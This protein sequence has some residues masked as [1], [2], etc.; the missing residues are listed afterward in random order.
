MSK[1]RNVPSRVRKV[2]RVKHRDL[3]GTGAEATLPGSFVYIDIDHEE[4]RIR[5]ESEIHIQNQYELSVDEENQLEQDIDDN[6]ELLRTAMLPLLTTIAGYDKATGEIEAIARDILETDV[7]HDNSV[8]SIAQA[9]T[10]LD[11]LCLLTQRC[12]NMP[13][14]VR[15]HFMTHSAQVIAEALPARLTSQDKLK[16]HRQF[17]DNIIA[18]SKRMSQEPKQGP[19]VSEHQPLDKR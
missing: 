12:K 9:V 15:T 16:R 13:E 14:S 19:Y 2:K 3:F 6:A 1:K 4:E 10:Q 17:M 11:I 5:A 18:V 8:Q 7:E